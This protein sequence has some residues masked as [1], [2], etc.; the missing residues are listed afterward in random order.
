MILNKEKK[1]IVSSQ[2]NYF[3]IWQYHPA[4]LAVCVLSLS[5]L[6]GV[7]DIYKYGTKGLTCE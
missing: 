2:D 4:D 7:P 6:I 5:L 3:D 1:V